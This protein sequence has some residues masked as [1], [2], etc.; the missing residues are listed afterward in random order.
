MQAPTV[1][2]KVAWDKWAVVEADLD[3]N[4]TPKEQQKHLFEE[5]IHEVKAFE[6]VK[7]AIKNLLTTYGLTMYTQ[8]QKNGNLTVSH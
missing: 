4:T 6:N 5:F 2:E 7:T 8:A 1:R 3:N